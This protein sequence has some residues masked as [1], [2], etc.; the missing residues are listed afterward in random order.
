MMKLESCAGMGRCKFLIAVTAQQMLALLLL[1]N[2]WY[3]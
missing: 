3:H 1:K 2:M